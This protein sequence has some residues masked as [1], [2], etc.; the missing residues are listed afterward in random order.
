MLH[1]IQLLFNTTKNSAVLCSDE[2]LMTDIVEP[3]CVLFGD[4][5]TD[6]FLLGL[7]MTKRDLAKE[8]Y[9]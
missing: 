3:F 5:F 1:S 7:A 9:H 8:T 4:H 2:Q 6:D